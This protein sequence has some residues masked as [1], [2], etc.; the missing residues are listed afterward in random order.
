MSEISPKLS[1][2]L[3]RTCRVLANKTRLKSLKVV[4]D[5]PDICVTDVAAALGTT[6]DE[7]SKALRALQSRGLISARRVSRWVLYF[8][9]P[10]PLVDSAKHF[11]KAVSKALHDDETYNIMDIERACTA[12]THVRRIAIIRLLYYSSPMSISSIE[13]ATAY[14][15]QAIKRHL[16]KLVDRQIV[17]ENEGAYSFCEPKDPFQ[18]QLLRIILNAQTA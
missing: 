3:W 7:A 16:A 8:P 5:N 9:S 4:I 10:D 12:Y 1:P 17:S 18:K 11:L 13:T 2:T 15:F 14:S 6:E